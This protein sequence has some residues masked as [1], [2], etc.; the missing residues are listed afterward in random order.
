MFSASQNKNE[1]IP[2]QERIE[3]VDENNNPIAV[4][5]R[6]EVHRQGLFHRS[7]LV[8]VYNQEGKVFLQKRHRNK[9]LYPGR[10]D[11]SA[12]G[13]VKAGEAAEDAALRELKEEV[14]IVPRQLKLIHTLKGTKETHNEFVYLFS[15][16]KIL[17]TPCPDPSEVEYGQFVDAEELST[18]V[19]EFPELLTPGVVYFWQKGLIFPR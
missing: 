15:A 8:L 16:G 6:N 12:T 7:V 17:D 9:N 2:G 1:F 11:L 3:V 4:L 5:S 14:G 18:M 19:K 10:W 13:H